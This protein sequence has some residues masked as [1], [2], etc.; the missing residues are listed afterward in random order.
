MKVQYD[1]Y[2]CIVSCFIAVGHRLES[3]G[4]DGPSEV[5]YKLSATRRL[6][7]PHDSSTQQLSSR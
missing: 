7:E 1:Q 2:Y 4:S 3:L 5:I 6:I